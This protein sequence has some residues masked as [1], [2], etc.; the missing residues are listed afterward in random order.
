MIRFERKNGDYLSGTRMRAA[1]PW[2]LAVG[3]G[4]R[5]SPYVDATRVMVVSLNA[6]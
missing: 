5:K 1:E 2:Q 6:A 4:G 3:G